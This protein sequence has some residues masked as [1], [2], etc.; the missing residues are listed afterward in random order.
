MSSQ[1]RFLIRSVMIIVF[2]LFINQLVQ[3]AG[4]IILARVLNDPVKFGEVNLLLQVFGMIAFVFEC[5]FQFSASVRLF[6]GCGGSH[7]K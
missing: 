5:R 4:N 3:T 1:Q 7:S 2:G 6:Y